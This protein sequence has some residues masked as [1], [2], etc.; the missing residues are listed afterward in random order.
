MRSE[1]DLGKLPI[2][3]RGLPRGVVA[4]RAKVRVTIALDR[5]IVEHFKESAQR[6]GALPYQ[7][8]INQA[9]RHAIE[10]S[11]SA[12]LKSEL[13]GDKAFIRSIARQIVKR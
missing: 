12:A 2:K 7:T 5:D 1:Y 9:L 4:S 8:Q 3:R 13:L 10:S 11:P 6:N